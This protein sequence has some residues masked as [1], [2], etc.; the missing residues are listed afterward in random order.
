MFY[1]GIYHNIKD[2]IPSAKE[3]KTQNVVFR[4]LLGFLAG[5]I[6]SFA[7]IPFDVAK[8]RIQGPQP[9]SGRI[10]F[11]VTQSMKLIAK[12]EGATALYR[13]FL[14]KVMRLG[15]GGAIMLFVYES[16]YDFL[17]LHT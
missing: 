9:P 3:S 14:P 4:L 8:S 11:T 15:P 17:K 6:A 1:F 16:V 2:F 10:Y 7:N 13:G 5:S 12:N